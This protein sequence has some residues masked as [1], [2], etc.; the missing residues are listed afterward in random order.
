MQIVLQLRAEA[1]AELRSGGTGSREAKRI[2]DEVEKRSASMEPMHSVPDH[3][4]FAAMFVVNV[5]EE[6]DTEELRA[7]LASL[8]AVEAAYTKPPDALP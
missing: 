6:A 8:E 2:L 1:A 5:P 7:S 4:P 3:D